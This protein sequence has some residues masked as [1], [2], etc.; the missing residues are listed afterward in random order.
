M[1]GRSRNTPSLETWPHSLLSLKR[2]QNKLSFF[3][4]FCIYNCIFKFTTGFSVYSHHEEPRRRT[5]ENTR[6]NQAPIFW[7]TLPGLQL[8]ILLYEILLTMFEFN[9]FEFTLTFAP[10]PQQ[11]SGMSAALWRLQLWGFYKPCSS[12]TRGND[13]E[14]RHMSAGVVVCHWCLCRFPVIQV[15]VTTVTTGLVRVT[16]QTFTGAWEL[17]FTCTHTCI[18]WKTFTKPGVGVAPINQEA[19][20]KCTLAAEENTNTMHRFP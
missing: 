7:Q 20:I 18:H 11:S 16:D 9:M 17:I 19:G 8:Q 14:C 1:T 3:T 15:I 12:T 4:N 10:K 5:E 13:E 2:Q 6:R